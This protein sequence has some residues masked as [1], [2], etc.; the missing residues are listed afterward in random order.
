MV[1]VEK[2]KYML[3]NKRKVS[4]NQL[5]LKVIEVVSNFFVSEVTSNNDVNTE[6]KRTV[7]SK[8]CLFLAS[9]LCE[10]MKQYVIKIVER[11]IY[12]LFINFW[13]AYELFKAIIL[14]GI[15][16]EIFYDKKFPTRWYAILKFLKYP[17]WIDFKDYTFV[18]RIFFL[19]VIKKE[20]CTHNIVPIDSLERIGAF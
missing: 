18:L 19:Q 2:T 13:Q 12:R 15:T 8:H 3:L 20:G 17:S 6:V 1:N 7:L 11:D 10:K 16:T 14:F 4:H 9:L 5:G